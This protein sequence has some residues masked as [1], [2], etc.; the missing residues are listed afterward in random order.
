MKLDLTDM[1]YA[2]SFALDRVEA[3]LLGVDTGHGRRVA[4]LSLLMGK[5][6]G[7]RDEELRDF[8][9]CCML[10]DNA[11]TEYIYEELSKSSILE[12]LSVNIGDIIKRNKSKLNHDHSV[13]G[14][15]NIRLLPFRT[16]VKNIVLCHHENA[17]GSGVL[18]MTAAETPLKAQIVHLA[19]LADTT[20]HLNLETMTVTELEDLRGWVQS[21][22]GSK[23]S[24]ET[25]ELFLKAVTYDKIV[26]LREKGFMH[27]LHEEFYS[28]LSDYS[29][30]EVRNIA[31]LFA[32]IIDY[33]SEFT[34]SHSKGVAEKAEIMAKHYGFDDEKTTRF[35]FAGAM[36]DIGKLA[37][38]NNILE[39]PGKLTTDEFTEMKNHASATYYILNQIKGIP[40]IVEWSSNHHEKLNGKGYPRGLTA[41]KLSFEEQLMACIDIY[42]ALTEKR[43]YKDGMSHE[44][45]ISIMQDMVNKGELNGDIVN[46]ISVIMA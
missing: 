4:Y 2:L 14:E 10:H 37:I 21:N 6:A 41:D 23:F 13:T 3:E 27:C 26:S 36:H 30:E 39:K 24:D 18:G 29:D 43:P 42:Q 11:L 5:E 28:E 32:K 38:S 40:D 35:Y 7:F 34:Q 46:D 16:D 44:K 20:C 19:D 12:G 8:T 22:A 9:G 33:K 31:D 1:L 17:D 25:I 45:T 15:M